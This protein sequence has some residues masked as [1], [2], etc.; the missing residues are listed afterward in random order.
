MG[1]CS[2]CT[3]MTQAW[4]LAPHTAPL[5]LNEWFLSTKIEVIPDTIQCDPHKKKKKPSGFWKIICGI[6]LTDKYSQT[7]TLSRSLNTE[8]ISD[9]DKNSP[10]LSKNKNKTKAHFFV[11]DS[12]QLANYTLWIWPNGCGPHLC[13]CP[14][15]YIV[16]FLL[17][18]PLEGH[19]IVLPLIK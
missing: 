17:T 5:A 10:L 12:V 1:R 16:Y 15:G 19:L 6:F 13:W 8:I 11:S 14:L 4:S 9:I 3:Y 18:A 7:W 2:S